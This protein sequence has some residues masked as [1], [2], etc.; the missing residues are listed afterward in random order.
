MGQLLHLMQA[1]RSQQ[2]IPTQCMPLGIV[3]GT[4]RPAPLQ[5]LAFFALSGTH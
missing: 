3:P 1:G 5:F 4:G 2:A